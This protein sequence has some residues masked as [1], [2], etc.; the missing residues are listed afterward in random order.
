M[1]IHILT[2]NPKGELS[3][4]TL[5]CTFAIGVSSNRP[6][7][8]DG[9]HLFNCDGIVNRKR[10]LVDVSCLSSNEIF[11]ISFRIL[12]LIYTIEQSNHV[13]F[14]DLNKFDKLDRILEKNILAMHH[15]LI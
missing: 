12:D 9:S 13:Q 6:N 10:S 7:S 5:Y 8:I 11:F 1:G 15:H 2:F 3:I 14:F 4:E